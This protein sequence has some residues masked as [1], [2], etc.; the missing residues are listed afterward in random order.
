MADGDAIALGPIRQAGGKLVHAFAVRGDADPERLRSNDF[1]LEWPPRSG[2]MRAFPEVDRAAWFGL[3]E[4]R[5]RI[6]TSQVP[7]LDALVAQLEG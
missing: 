5:A 7:L 1:E 2:R 4:A 3:E 6:L